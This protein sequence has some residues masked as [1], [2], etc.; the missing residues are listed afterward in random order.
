MNDER[1]ILTHSESYVKKTNHVILMVGIISLVIFILG[2]V[3]VLQDNEEEEQYTAP[4]FTSNDDA[5]SPQKTEEPEKNIEFETEITPIST[6]GEGKNYP[7]QSSKDNQ[8][9]NKN[10]NVL[11]NSGDT[12]NH[13]K[14]RYGIVLFCILLFIK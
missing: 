14:H 3:L 10:E 1:E 4:V 7:P 6:S 9:L 13:N 5:F 11:L 2:L 8:N 12:I